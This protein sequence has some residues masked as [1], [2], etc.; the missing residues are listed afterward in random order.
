MGL[1]IDAVRPICS[2]EPD[3]RIAHVGF[4]SV[5]GVDEALLP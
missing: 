5:C 2:G 3:A 1:A 4:C